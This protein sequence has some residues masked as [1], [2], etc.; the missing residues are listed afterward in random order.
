MSKDTNNEDLSFKKSS[1]EFPNG[2]KE[3]L[4]LNCNI[5]REEPKE[6]V[7]TENTQKNMDCVYSTDADYLVHVEFQ[8]TGNNFKKDLRRFKFYNAATEFKYNKEVITYIIYGKKIN[9]R[10]AVLEGSTGVFK[11]ITIFLSE[12]YIED[13]LEDIKEKINRGEELSEKDNVM[14]SISPSLNYRNKLKPLLHEVI[15]I[16]KTLPR[17]RDI[18]SIILLLSDKFLDKAEKSEIKEELGMCDLVRELT[19][20]AK[21]E[22]RRK[23]IIGVLHLLTDEQIADSFKVDIEYVREIR[24]KNS[25]ATSNSFG[26][27]K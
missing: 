4:G 16:A 2:I 23:N 12:I 26:F 15:N 5:T 10:E 9:R 27:I 11:P 7:T 1:M 18:T 13:I 14:L 21:E 3:W 6:V 24:K 25:S 8:S 17:K 22:E 20:D 19:E